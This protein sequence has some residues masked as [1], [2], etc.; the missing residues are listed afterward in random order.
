[1]G[2]PRELLGRQNL[3]KM[4]DVTRLSRI[5]ALSKRYFS[6]DKQGLLRCR[7]VPG[8]CRLAP[9]KAKKFKDTDF[10]VGSIGFKAAMQKNVIL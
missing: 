10:T 4:G 1:M 7:L 8:E 6:S 5:L 9:S 2:F 3:G